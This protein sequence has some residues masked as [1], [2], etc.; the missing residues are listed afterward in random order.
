MK[1]IIAGSR[2]IGDYCILI[3]AITACPWKITTVL[4]G[5]ARG[6]DQLGESWAWVREIPVE[7]YPAKWNKYGRS[8]GVIRNELML[9]HAEAVLA[10]WNGKSQGTDHM[11]R[12]AKKKGI[13]V[14]V[15]LVST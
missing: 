11:I 3:E 1:T 9:T 4:S 15:H 7:V 2:T 10:V 14:Y 13:P 6:I 5:G 12:I 8:A